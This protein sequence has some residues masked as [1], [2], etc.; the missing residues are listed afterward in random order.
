MKRYVAMFLTL[1]ML[2]V[3]LMPM[4]AFAES[5][6]GLEA[7][8]KGVKSKIDIPEDFIFSKNYD[9][10]TQQDGKKIWYLRWES[11]DD[12]GGSI[13]VSADEKGT[14][15]SYEH[16]KPYNY[17]DRKKLPKISKDDA[18]KAA[19]AFV[20]KVNP[21]AAA[22]VKLEDE[23]QLLYMSSDYYFTFYRTEK[24]IP[25]YEN[26]IGI[27]VDRDSGEVRYYYYNWNDGLVFPDSSKA[28]A[29]E[30]AQKAFKEKMG[31]KLVY[32]Y[33]YDYENE[34]I[35]IFPAYVP[36]YDSMYAIDAL[37]GEMIQTGYYYVFA[38]GMGATADMAL[39]SVAEVEQVVLSPEELEAAEEASKLISKDDAEK[40]AR[41]LSV[42]GLTDEYKLT[43]AW[44]S[45]AWPNRKDFLW[46]LSFAKEDKDGRDYR[47]VNV[48]INAE[49]KEIM[50][51]YTSM[52][53]DAKAQ[54][55]YDED[56]AKAAAEKFLKEFKPDLFEQ[57][58]YEG[59]NGRGIVI[60][61][62]EDGKEEKPLQYSLVYTRMVNGI[63][64]PDNSL[65]VG[66]DAVNGRIYSFDMT[67]FDEKFPTV[68][69]N[70]TPD[71][72]YETLFKDLG[73][74]LQYKFVYN[75]NNSLYEKVIYAPDYNNVEVKLVYAL[76]T[77][78][79]WIF[80]PETGA[81][82]NHDG[83]PYEEVKVA[84]YSDIDGHY[85]EDEIKILA[86]YGISLDGN[87]FRP[88]DS[89]TQKDFLTL[90]SKTL[91]D[92][93]VPVSERGGDKET[94]AL[95][96]Y[97]MRQGI[98]K[99]REKAPNAVLTREDSVKFI[100]RALK[101]DKVADIKGI[102]KSIFKDED[103]INPDLIG[104]ISIAQGL[105]IISGY[106]GYF[107]PKGELTRAQ[108]AIIIYKYLQV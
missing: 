58:K 25:L 79:P 41:G 20:K 97:M 68:K 52:P 45:R 73:L 77:R 10:Y 3:S 44:L 31:L 24:G 80:D 15:Y 106:D 81:I 37:T 63:P 64:F 66:Y 11:K 91:Q 32:K 72:A 1:A 59:S 19:K 54:A 34:K 8:I 98:V 65:R 29:P 21:E 27:T 42:L 48:S 53:Y 74:E 46:S 84:E 33:S 49:T 86:A 30:A 107:N 14:I 9:V 26:N 23:N 70:V 71:K 89:I 16:Y 7:A 56:D 57:T 36:V 88:N 102:Y 38:G 75:N 104:Y 103:E 105:N 100:I 87:E 94:D 85:A 6:K 101:Y 2:F 90:L 12:L 99:E 4:Q 62:A 51:F 61:L 5:D 82:L 47:Y 83:K 96:S 93:Y 17:S 40:V 22:N 67:W 43:N 18:L 78:K 95:Y 69:D 50:N 13:M 108:A 60:P 35:N 55:K 92:Y 39:K 76:N 28:I